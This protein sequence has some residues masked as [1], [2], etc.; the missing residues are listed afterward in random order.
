MSLQGSEVHVEMHNIWHKIVWLYHA[1]LFYSWLYR[2]ME[3]QPID[4][5]MKE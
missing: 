2:P 1:T 4:E 5:G 3:E